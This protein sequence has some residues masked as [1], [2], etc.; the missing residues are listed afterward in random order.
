[1]PETPEP[2]KVNAPPLGSDTAPR[3]TRT[4]EWRENYASTA[5]HV[6]PEALRAWVESS[7]EDDARRGHGDRPPWG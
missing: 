4:R 3:K 1:M 7:D 2:P 6:D 5:D